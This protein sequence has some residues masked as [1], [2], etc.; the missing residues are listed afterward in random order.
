VI[1]IEEQNTYFLNPGYIFVS[2]EPHLIHT[3]LGSCIAVCLWDSYHKFGGMS[4][5]IYSKILGNDR[6]VKFGEVAIPYLIKLMLGFGAKE[7][8][9][10]AHIIGGGEHPDFKSLV[11]AENA[12][13]AD[14]LLADYHIEVLSRD[15][16]GQYGRKVVFNSGTGEILIYKINKIRK[17]DWYGKS[18]TK[19]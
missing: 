7:S 4:H 1:T 9:I 2:Q 8:Q 13:L 19:N 12:D 3:V 18:R 17:D 6:N 10:K 5:Y 15:V 11:G 16:K 14:K